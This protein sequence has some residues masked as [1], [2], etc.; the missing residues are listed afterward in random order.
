MVLGLLIIYGLF[1]WLKFVEIYIQFW[2]SPPLIY[3]RNTSKSSNLRVGKIIPISRP[4]SYTAHAFEAH[5]EGRG[6]T[7]M[8]NFKTFKPTDFA[9]GKNDIMS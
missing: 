1:C 8:A 2:K 6:R 7:V 5:L 4:F 3:G 9:V